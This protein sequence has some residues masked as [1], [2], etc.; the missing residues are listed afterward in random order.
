V[1]LKF[2]PQRDIMDIFISSHSFNETKFVIWNYVPIIVIVWRLIWR[3]FK[4]SVGLCE[5]GSCTE[6]LWNVI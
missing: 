6:T 2:P 3:S 5:Q 1:I 4:R